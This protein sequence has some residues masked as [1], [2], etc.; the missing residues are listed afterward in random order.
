MDRRFQRAAQIIPELQLDEGKF[1][2]ELSDEQILLEAITSNLASVPSQ[3]TL[4]K[5]EKHLEHFAGF[6][7]GRGRTFYTARRKDISVFINHLGTP[8][9]PEPHPARR[10]CDWCSLHGFPDGRGGNGWSASTR[11]SFLSAIRFL[12]RHFFLD[13][14]LPDIDPSAHIPSPKVAVIPGYAP[15]R[16]EVK[17]FLEGPGKPRDRVLAS[18]VF[19]TASRR[20]TFSDAR[21]RDIDLDGPNPRWFFVGKGQVVDEVPLHPQL[22]R[23]LRKYRNWQQQEAARNP[24][25]R[26]ALDHSDTAF[27]LL[28]RTG[29]RVHPNTIGKMI[30]W[31]AIRAG[32]AVKDAEGTRDVPSGLTSKLSPHALRRAWAQISL[33]DGVPLD[34]IQTALNHK[35]IST[36]RRHYAPGKPERAQAAMRGMRL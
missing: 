12:Y 33:D 13:D 30:R 15:S 1:S 27:V 8:G 10:G 4:D 26:A 25:I 21:W 35:D 6:L 3:P 29:K 7:R 18:W 17:R 31:R 16:D 14:E 19:F 22:V 32:I 2:L 34:D 9:G 36:T 24:A 23:E 20:A 28:T 5:Y 11:K